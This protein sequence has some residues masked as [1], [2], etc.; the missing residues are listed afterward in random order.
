VRLND[1]SNGPWLGGAL[2][3]I[4]ECATTSLR[5]GARPS[6]GRPRPR[7][8]KAHVQL[9]RRQL[10]PQ[11]RDGGGE[12]VLLLQG[13]PGRA[14]S[15]CRFAP[16]LIHFISDFSGSPSP[17]SPPPPAPRLLPP[18]YRALHPGCTASVRRAPNGYYNA[19]L[20]ST[21]GAAAIV[22]S[23]PKLSIVRCSVHCSVC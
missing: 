21:V 22:V 14:R 23:G 16:P 5:A 7:R 3:A 19:S 17:P 11:H 13:L 15:H 6:P 9:R 8:S 18:P 4:A 12:R 2:V 1:S 20:L 10:R